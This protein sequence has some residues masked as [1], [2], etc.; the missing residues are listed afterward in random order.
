M[1]KRPLR[2]CEHAVARYC[3]R[4]A[5]VAREE[6]EARLSSAVFQCAARFGAQVVRRPGA[7]RAIL[8]FLR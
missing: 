7:F 4:V 1:M 2:V 5:D 6:A 8:N 3:E